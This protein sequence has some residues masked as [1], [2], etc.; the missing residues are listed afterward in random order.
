MKNFIFLIFFL[1]YLL[2]AKQLRTYHETT[3]SLGMG[4]VRI[5][6]K[7]EAQAF[8][9]NPAFQSYHSGLN[10][11]L[12]DAGAGINGLQAYETFKDVDFSGGL[13]SMSGLFGKPL[14]AGVWGWGALSW[15]KF[16]FYY[17]TSYDVSATLKDPVLPKLDIRYFQDSFYI[18]GF[19]T[20]VWDNLG[21]GINVKRVERVGGE[22][23]IGA[24]Q[25]LDPNFNSNLLE[26]VKNA[27]NRSGQAF[28]LDLG[29]AYQWDMVFKPTLGVAWQDV[30]TTSFAPSNPN[31]PVPPLEENLILSGTIREKVWGFGLAGGFEYRHIR[32]ADEQLGKKIHL[33][34]ELN[35]PLIDLRAGLYQ[36]YTSYGVGLDLWLLRL[37]AALFSLETGQYPGQT[38]QERVLL[39]LTMDLSIDPDFEVRD[40]SGNR[41]KIFKRR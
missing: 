29:V 23:V 35:L 36:G 31:E 17:L 15:E 18:L 3:R 26:N 14:W 19:G 33:G 28:G 12:A 9:W 41:R 22:E 27:L 2:H 38:P 1:P 21:F 37:D 30:G 10:I 5:P 11:T 8:V 7:N 39:T 40:S 13:S 20:K 34:A 25:L 24:S 4:G 6:H 32:Q 16:G